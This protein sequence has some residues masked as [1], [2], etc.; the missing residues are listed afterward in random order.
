MKKLWQDFKEFLLQGNLIT[1][2][3]AFI[4]ATIFAEVIKAFIVDLITPIIGLIVGKP[5][6]GHLSFTIRSSHFMYGDFINVAITFVVTAAAVFFFVV[7]PYEIFQARK[8]KDPTEKDC[9][10]CTSSIPLAA[11]RCPQCTAVI[12]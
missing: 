8:P 2:A 11:T 1:L 12:G 7:K 10:E 6:F 9:P 3:V 5:S 4:I